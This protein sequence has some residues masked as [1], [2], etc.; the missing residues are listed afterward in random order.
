MVER[1]ADTVIGGVSGIAVVS[2]ADCAKVDISSGGDDNGGDDN[3]GGD[4]RRVGNGIVSIAVEDDIFSF[5]E[6]S[7]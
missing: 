4:G 1:V 6:F 5:V 3:G 7:G 2:L